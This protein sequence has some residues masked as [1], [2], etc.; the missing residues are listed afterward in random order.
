MGAST[1]KATE[2]RIAEILRRKTLSITD[3]RKKILSIFLAHPDALAHG[4][5]EKKAGEKFDRV[6]V[7]RTLQT[8]V[9]KG[10]LHTIPTA[11]NSVLYALCKDCD[12]GHHHDDHVHF[13]CN[14]C[15]K[16]Y[17]LDGVV[18]PRINLHEGY[19]ASSVQVLM[20]GICRECN[21]G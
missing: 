12:E 17:C 15:H 3:S 19:R 18:T 9:D 1:H 21:P 2:A 16:T 11:D 8:F 13:I 7:Y 4:D 20:H 5:I 6:T 14:N 10:I